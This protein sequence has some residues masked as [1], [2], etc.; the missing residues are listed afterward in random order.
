MNVVG[1]IENYARG[2]QVLISD[3]T[4]QLVEDQVTVAGQFCMNAKGAEEALPL[5]VVRGLGGPVLVGAA[6]ELRADV[7]R[8]T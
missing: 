6:P 3:S 4:Y 8:R 1:R 7:R 2:G 5:H